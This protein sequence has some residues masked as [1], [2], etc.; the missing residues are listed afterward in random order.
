MT[1]YKVVTADVIEVFDW[2]VSDQETD[3]YI[4][5]HRLCNISGDRTNRKSADCT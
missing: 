5:R 2:S 1:Y 3:W 4:V